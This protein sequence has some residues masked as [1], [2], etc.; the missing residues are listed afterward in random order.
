M[1]YGISKI[2]EIETKTEIQTMKKHNVIDAFEVAAKRARIDGKE[3]R[4]TL[5]QIQYLADLILLNYEHDIEEIV[6]EYRT[7]LMLTKKKARYLIWIHIVPTLYPSSLYTV[8]QCEKICD[9]LE[10]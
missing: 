3:E 10:S 1:R 2:K 8:E 6:E 7:S 9:V 4:A 5:A